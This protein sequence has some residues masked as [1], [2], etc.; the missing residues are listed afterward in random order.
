MDTLQLVLESTGFSEE[1]EDTS[2]MDVRSLEVCEGRFCGLS[3][4][5]DKDTAACP[6]TLEGI[7]PDRGRMEGEMTLGAGKG[8]GA[9][10]SDLDTGFNAVCV[11]C[12]F[13]T[14][15]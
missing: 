14:A 9:R 11:G 3:S 5:E 10:Q 4:P 6:L 8:V 7:V 1:A 15:T 2:L 12:L 13:M